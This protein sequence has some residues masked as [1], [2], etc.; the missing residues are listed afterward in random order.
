MDIADCYRILGLTSVASAQEI[1]TSYRRLARQWHPDVNPDNQQAHDMFIRVTEAYKVLLKVTP[2]PMVPS[3]GMPVSKAP[4]PRTAASVS[5]PGPSPQPTHPRRAPGPRS[6]SASSASAVPHPDPAYRIK[7]QAYEQ[8][9]QLVKTKRY[10][11]AIALI[12]ALNQKLP[13]DPEIRQWQA[14]I[15]QRWGRQLI[16]ERKYNQARAYLRKAMQ[17]DPGNKSLLSEIEQDLNA[18]RMAV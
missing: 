7:L 15:Y 2:Q 6:A 16:T 10:P 3:H 14:I 18:I 9:R 1:K 8:L 11:R 12:E 13:Q 17:T 4:P 5:S